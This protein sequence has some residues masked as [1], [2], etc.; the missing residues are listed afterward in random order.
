MVKFGHQLE[1]HHG[2]LLVD[3]EWQAWCKQMPGFTNMIRKGATNLSFY[4]FLMFVRN[5]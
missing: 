5:V 4:A 2:E 3:G 1:G